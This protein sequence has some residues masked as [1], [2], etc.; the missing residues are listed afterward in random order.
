VDE[1]WAR[2]PLI[3]GQGMC[4]SFEHRYPQFNTSLMQSRKL[5][6]TVLL[7]L[8]AAS[9]ARFKPRRGETT[10]SASGAAGSIC[11]ETLRGLDPFRGTR[12]VEDIDLLV[13]HRQWLSARRATVALKSGVWNSD[14]APGEAHGPAQ[15][16]SYGAR[17]PSA[18]CTQRRGGHP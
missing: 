4:G 11:C 12:Q 18:D 10:T 1:P 2:L 17:E 9:G 14:A 13:R 15:P 5:P 8:F 16:H 7:Q 6:T 3:F